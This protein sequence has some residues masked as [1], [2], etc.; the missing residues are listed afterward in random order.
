[1]AAASLLAIWLTPSIQD[2]M[3]S[4]ASWD[5]LVNFNAQYRAIQLDSLDALSNPT[6]PGVLISIP[7][8]GYNNH[9]LDQIKQYVETGNTLVLMDDSGYGNEVLQYLGVSPRFNYSPLLDPLFCYKNQYFPR[10]TDFS[11]FLTNGGINSIVLNHATCIDNVLPSQCLAWSSSFSFVDLDQ[12][13]SQDDSEPQ[14]PFV[15]AASVKAGLGTIYL[16]SDPSLIINSMADQDNNTQFVSL[17]IGDSDSV[18]VDRAHL[19]KSNLDIAKMNLLT[20]RRTFSSP[21]A[22]MGLVIVIFILVSYYTF[23]KG[24]IFG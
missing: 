6:N 1:V 15:V 4:N 12:N 23:K 18:L 16:I 21:F 22:L 3:A 11:S 5:G 13:G 20:L 8:L 10:I 7:N 17:L 9:D 2:F 19:V 14:G 24:E